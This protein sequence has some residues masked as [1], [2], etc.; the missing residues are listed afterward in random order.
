MITAFSDKETI[1]KDHQRTNKV[2]KAKLLARRG[3]GY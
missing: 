3:Y 2:L 1:S